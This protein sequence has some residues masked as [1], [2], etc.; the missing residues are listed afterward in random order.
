MIK[1]LGESWSWNASF[2]IPDEGDTFEGV[3]PEWRKSPALEISPRYSVRRWNDGY[4]LAVKSG[5]DHVNVEYTWYS[6]LDEML[7]AMYPGY[8]NGQELTDILKYTIPSWDGEPRQAVDWTNPPRAPPEA[9][10]PA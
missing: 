5:T 3:N 6:T 4:I 2:I 10:Y 8:P 1:K 9:L 7:G